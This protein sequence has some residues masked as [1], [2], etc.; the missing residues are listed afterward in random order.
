MAK[1]L[2]LL[3]LI[4]K[5]LTIAYL[6]TDYRMKNNNDISGLFRFNYSDESSVQSKLIVL[7]L[8]PVM[9]NDPKANPDMSGEFRNPFAS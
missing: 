5:G 7:N 2:A 4:L 1:I 8:E 9:Q 3:E 6:F